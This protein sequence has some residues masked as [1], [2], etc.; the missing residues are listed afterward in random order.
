VIRSSDGLVTQMVPNQDVAWHAGNWFVNS[1]AIGIEQEG[2]ALQGATWFTENLYRASA[3][4]VR[5]LTGEFDIPRDREHIVGHD[6]VP[7]IL[8]GYTIGMHWDPGPYWDWAHFMQLIGAPINPQ[9]H[10]HASPSVI[11]I[12]PHFATNQPPVADCGVTPPV[13]QPAQPSSFVY[14]RTAPSADAPYLT[15]AVYGPGTTCAQDA[16]DK[17]VTGQS[18]V[19]AGE[20][21]DW[22]GIWFNGQEGWFFDPHGANSVSGNAMVVTPRPGLASIP[23][24]GR[25]YPEASAYPPGIP[26]QAVTPVEYTIQAGQPY[27]ATGPIQSS[28]YWAPTY[29]LNPADHKVVTG[30]TRYYQVRLGHRFFFV[31]AN[32]VNVVQP[33]R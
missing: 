6:D 31:M 13:P 25:A 16:G 27:V 32:D 10:P 20:S 26:P 18:F 12:A 33:T 28:Y 17:A 7:G 9:G 30:Q 4:L 8:P 15:D 5:H 23:V 1:H 3:A 29:T 21:G 22:T 11:T 24:Y 2:F 14:L 19:V